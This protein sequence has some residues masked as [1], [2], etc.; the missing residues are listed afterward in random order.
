M[1][2]TPNFIVGVT[3]FA[4]LSAGVLLAV[5]DPA[6]FDPKQAML[7]G[8]EDG[9]ADGTKSLFPSLPGVGFT[10]SRPASPVVQPLRQ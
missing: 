6:L 1:K 4:A 10:V 7:V 9:P 8:A 3:A 2:T 5:E